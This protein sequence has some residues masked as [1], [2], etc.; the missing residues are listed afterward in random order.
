MNPMPVVDHGREVQLRWIQYICPMRGGKKERIRGKLREAGQEKRSSGTEE[1]V[2]GTN[3]EVFL[4]RKK[5]ASRTL[6]LL[7]RRGQKGGEKGK[8]QQLR[9]GKKEMRNQGPM[10][11]RK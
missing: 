10:K 9:G 1:A 6:L 3:S 4:R 11:P 2:F 8:Q 5:S 7:H